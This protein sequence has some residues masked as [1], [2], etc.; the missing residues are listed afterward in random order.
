MPSRS[1]VPFSRR[2]CPASR[3]RWQDREGGPGIPA[4]PRKGTSATAL[5]YPRVPQRARC[6]LL[7]IPG[8][9]PG[10]AE[11]N[12]NAGRLCRFSTAAVQRPLQ[13][14]IISA[15]TPSGSSDGVQQ[16]RPAVQ[17]QHNE[18]NSKATYRRWEGCS[19]DCVQGLRC[20]QYSGCKATDSVPILHSI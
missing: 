12:G 4:L 20:Q 8:D 2:R 17:T 15:R 19:F 10:R 13:Q 5:V 1:P 18:A 9:Q 3:A 14:D 6:G 11:D 16:G 7:P